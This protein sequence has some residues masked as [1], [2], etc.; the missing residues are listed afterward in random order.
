VGVG[1][2]I[3]RN[4]LDVPYKCFAQDMLY[5]IVMKHRL[6]IIHQYYQNKAKAD[7]RSGLLDVYL[8][9]VAELDLSVFFDHIEQTLQKVTIVSEQEIF[10][11]FETVI[12]EGSQGILLDQEYGFFLMLLGQILLLKM[13]WRW[14]VNMIWV[15]RMCIILLVHILLDMVMD[16]WPMKVLVCRWSI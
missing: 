4:S 7:G 5:P 6:E 12:F 1:P 9:F 2:T 15:I 13:Q 8:A 10:S 16:R 14:F 11:R 3:E